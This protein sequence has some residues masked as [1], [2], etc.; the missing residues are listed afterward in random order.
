MDV[1]ALPPRMSPDE[2]NL[3]RRMH[4]EQDKTPTDIAEAL[5]RSLSAV[6][7]L[8]AQKKA[9]RPICRPKVLSEAKIDRIVAVLDEMV[10]EADGNYEVTLD[11]LVRRS[12]L[13]V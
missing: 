8:I 11:Q 12:R 9:P 5:G 1:A 4:F 2:K 7:R 13:K 6:C 10:D 3:A